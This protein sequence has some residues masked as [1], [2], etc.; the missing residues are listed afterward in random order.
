M[1]FKSRN[2]LTCSASAAALFLSLAVLPRYP[3]QTEPPAAP[4]VVVPAVYYEGTLGLNWAAPVSI[5][6]DSDRILVVTQSGTPHTIPASQITEI[7]YERIPGSPA[8]RWAGEFSGPETVAGD[9]LAQ[10]LFGYALQGLGAD[11]LIPYKGKDHFVYLYWEMDNA[12]QEA[13]FRVRE[14]DR[15]SLLG[16]LQKAS[17]RA[18]KNFPSQ[19]HRIREGLQQAR[20][21]RID[22]KLDRKVWLTG[23]K[24]E[25]GRYQ[26]V[27]LPREENRGELYVFSGKKAKPGKIVTVAQVRMG[28]PNPAP[29]RRRV[30]YGPKNSLPTIVR[31]HT[32]KH[33]LTLLP[34]RRVLALGRALW[35]EN[36]LSVPFPARNP[37]AGDVLVSFVNFQNGTAFR[38]P[39]QHQH[40]QS[41]GDRACRGYLYVSQESVAYDP[42]LSPGYS[43]GFKMSRSNFLKI[44]RAGLSRE[45]FLRLSGAGANRSLKFTPPLQLLDTSDFV[46][47]F[48]L[49]IFFF[50]SLEEEFLQVL[51]IY[52]PQ[53]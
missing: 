16:G 1:K 9:A 3:A 41:T 33:T 15:L 46:D 29:T 32:S 10:D 28:E 7:V 48:R 27:L 25:L 26:F 49:S 23:V 11:L 52:S 53:Q 44:S 34:A 51:Q 37:A 5:R 36:F 42:V 43:D 31:L 20:R 4:P 45:K 38:F 17:G 39:V 35:H 6:M 8:A 40:E 47:F 50:E 24:L 12:L 14:R 30:D 13:V 2:Q 19:R 18:W 22:I 21:N